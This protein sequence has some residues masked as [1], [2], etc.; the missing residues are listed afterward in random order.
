MKKYW[1]PISIGLAGLIVIFNPFK[2]PKSVMADGKNPLEPPVGSGDTTGT[3][4]YAYPLK[5]GSSGSIVVL[6]QQAL[7]KKYLPKFGA[8]G[9]F[10]TET[11]AAVQKLLGKKTIDSKKDIDTI[12]TLNGLVYTNGQYVPKLI[13]APQSTGMMLSDINKLGF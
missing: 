13:A 7:T 3:S 12:A 11:E 9:D 10:G 6:L 1:I 4:K 5:K 8:D 2:K